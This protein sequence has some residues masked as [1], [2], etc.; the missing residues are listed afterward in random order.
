MTN[1]SD[2][3]DRVEALLAQMAEQQVR[4]QQVIDSNSRAIEA[5]SV[6][7]AE[8]RAIAQ[9]NS[10]AVSALLQR[11]DTGFNEVIQMMTQL[12][13]DA[14]ADRAELRLLIEA[15]AGNSKNG[16]NGEAN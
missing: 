11:M 14:A 7:I 2:R 9:A 4:T 12:A 5:N 13:N 6:A 16:G 10:E 1:S 8:T 15:I 3:L